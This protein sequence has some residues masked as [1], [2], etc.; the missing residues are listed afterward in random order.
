MKNSPEDHLLLNSFLSLTYRELR[1]WT[2][3]RSSPCHSLTR[4]DLS[5]KLACMCWMVGGSWSTRRKPTQA[6]GEHADSTLKPG[7]LAEGTGEYVTADGD[8][9][10]VWVTVVFTSP[11]MGLSDIFPALV[12]F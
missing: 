5:F 12:A 3:F 6:Q 10:A 8:K 11:I 4:V 9:L 2:W 7:Q 1:G